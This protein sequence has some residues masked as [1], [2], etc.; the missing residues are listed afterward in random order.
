MSTGRGNEVVALSVTYGPVDSF[1]QGS[2]QVNTRNR[3]RPH[4]LIFI[5]KMLLISVFF[6]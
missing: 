3:S 2:D 5:V 1:L 6:M 4:Y